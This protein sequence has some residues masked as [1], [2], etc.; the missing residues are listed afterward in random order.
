MEM[1]EEITRNLDRGESEQVDTGYHP[2]GKPYQ[3]EEAK[4][5]TPKNGEIVDSLQ[6]ESNLSKAN[7]HTDKERLMLAK[8]I[9][10]LG[11]LP[12][13]S[14][15]S[16]NMGEIETKELDEILTEFKR[17]VVGDAMPPP[18]V[19]NGLLLPHKLE[20]EED[21][22]KEVNKNG[23]IGLPWIAK[24]DEEGKTPTWLPWSTK[25]DLYNGIWN[26]ITK[27]QEEY[28]RNQ[29]EQKKNVILK[30]IIGDLNELF[31]LEK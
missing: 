27:I 6:E 1:L 11:N 9:S 10:L 21:D 13:T 26:D 5:L 29:K 18:P 7:Q 15:Q 8:I 4:P 12:S 14:D 2:R 28:K 17:K 19:T 25:K 24:N 31:L 30:R 3:P 16:K 23:P 22:S 20:E